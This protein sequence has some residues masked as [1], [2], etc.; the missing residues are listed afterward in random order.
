M[1]KM[2][3]YTDE[4]MIVLKNFAAINPNMIILPDKFTV[5]NGLKKSVIAYYQFEK[6]YDYSPYGIYDLNE[7]R[8][9]M[10]QMDEWEL[11]VKERYVAILDKGNNS[12]VKYN[13]TANKYLP[14]I[15]ER[16]PE[17][18]EKTSKELEFK[19]TAEKLSSLVKITS[20]L[21]SERIYFRNDPK[22]RLQMISAG[23]NLEESINP[24]EITLQKDDIEVNNLGDDVL[25]FDAKEFKIL[26]GEYSVKIAAKGISHWHNELSPQ[27]DYYIGIKKAEKDEG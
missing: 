13:L 14:E 27:V 11:H 22:G 18:F 23:V 20:I 17:N 24:F 4:E 15:S 3:K 7:F 19:L 21:N 26:P 10:D 2:F 6:P 5:I 1:S 9:L 25:Y 8:N 16:V 12:E